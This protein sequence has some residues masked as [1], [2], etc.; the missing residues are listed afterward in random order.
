[1]TSIT[2]NGQSQVPPGFRFHPT[3]EELLQYYLKKKVASQKIDLDVIQ[4]VDLNKLEP[5]DIQEKCKIGSTP[6][7]DWYFF[8]HKDKKYP[9]GT[10]TNRA[11][12]SGFWKATGR[13]KAIYGANS[14]RIGMR[15]TLVFYKGRAP[16]GQKSD[17]IMHEYRLDDNNPTTGTTV[18]TTDGSNNEEGWVV[19]RVF[20]KKNQHKSLLT[21]HRSG[22]SITPPMITTTTT[23]YWPTMIDS[24][25]D[26]QGT[27]E[28][29]ML[30]SMGCENHQDNNR[31]FLKLPSLQHDRTIDDI[32][33]I[34]SPNDSSSCAD[35]DDDQSGI[36]DWA[37]LDRLV[38]SHLNGQTYNNNNSNGSKQVSNND[39]GQL[40]MAVH[41]LASPSSSSSSAMRRIAPT[42]THQEMI[43]HQNNEYCDLWSF[44]RSSNDQLCHLS[45]VPD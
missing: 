1:M 24:C 7:N 29:I 31:Q 17:W 13:D 33:H 20:M 5:W 16:H 3:E 42:S 21:D 39:D 9:T 44:A 36:Q 40:M 38:A 32:H 28:Q 45:N 26:D 11:T 15:K 2:V 34:I 19:C 27:L 41:Q 37:A 22:I 8:S 14:R 35:A 10:R 25:N 18:T 43:Y 23:N 12:A 30:G 4:D 6:Q